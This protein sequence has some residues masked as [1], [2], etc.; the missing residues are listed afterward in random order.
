MWLAL[1]E[2]FGC[3]Y[4]DSLHINLKLDISASGDLHFVPKIV[5]NGVKIKGGI[6][7]FNFYLVYTHF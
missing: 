4:I 5:H 7:I 2:R 1:V 6:V 3:T